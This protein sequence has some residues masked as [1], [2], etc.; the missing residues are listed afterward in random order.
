[1]TDPDRVRL[2]QR[3]RRLWFGGLFAWFCVGIVVKE[4]RDPPFDPV[5]MLVNLLLAALMAWFFVWLFT[6]AVRNQG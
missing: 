1:M 4:L 2:H 3:K 5:R 6:K